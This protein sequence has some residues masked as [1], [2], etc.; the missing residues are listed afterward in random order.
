MER[1][2]LS[3]LVFLTDGAKRDFAPR[4]LVAL[5]D[6]CRGLRCVNLGDVFQI[7]AQALPS[8]FFPSDHL[9]LVTRFAWL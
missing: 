4:G 1:L 3:G 6:R 2:D 8:E 7:G 5:A 9:C